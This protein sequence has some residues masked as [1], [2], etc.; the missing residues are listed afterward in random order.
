MPTFAELRSKAAKMADATGSKIVNT[1]DRM[2]SQPSKNI[3]WDADIRSKPPPPPKPPK[4]LPPPSRTS[5]A[6]SASTVATSQ[7]ERTKPPVPV[8]R[9]GSSAS[10]APS[11]GR[12]VSQASH[13]SS[14]SLN[15]S[16][17]PPPTVRRETRPDSVSPPPAYPSSSSLPR[18]QEPQAEEDA[19]IDRFDWANLSPEDKQIFFSWLD[20]FFARYLHV[21]VP[22]RTADT[23]Q[24]VKVTPGGR[25]PSPMTGPPQVQRTSRPKTPP[26]P[27]F[28]SPST[29]GPAA[30]AMTYPPP[31]EHGSA[32]A[33][34]AHY[35][36]PHTHWSSA[37]YTD[38][39]R[40]APPL[41]GNGHMAYAGG[42]E[43]NGTT[44]TISGGVLFSDLSMCWYSVSWP[45]TAPPTHDA[46]DSRIVHRS[47]RYLPRPSPWS[48]EQLID[49]HET[50]GETVAGFAESFEDGGQPCARGECWD[51]ANEALKYFEQYDYVPKPVPSVSRTHG[52]L[53]YEGKASEKGK[54]QMGRWRGGDDRVRRGDIVEWRSARV[55]T[56]P[57]SWAMLGN[58]DHTAVIVS[59]MVPKTSVADGMAVRP[60]EM[61]TLEVIEQ[62]LGKPPKRA[63]YDLSQFQE[64]EVWIYRPVGL[65]A[66]V[67]TLLGAKCPEGVNALSVV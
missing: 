11:L 40:M 32:G 37:W 31:T 66:Y 58:P 23:V 22:P 7:A 9:A 51:L 59:D 45:Q 36:S 43:S 50:Y 56:G 24:H 67:G 15:A 61:G 13:S 30:F 64:G 21:S 48:R 4:P 27:M 52:H 16:L 12:S 29:A 47:A 2:K 8:R 3:N 19:D 10:A 62:S 25:T 57:L 33:D 20:E 39:D 1:K 44:Q 42:W 35:F 65:E 63:R 17:G 41:K 54:T 5:S 28:G 18:I 38:G 6:S 46:N 26:R 53:I 60:A 34:L 14:T 55:G 49:A